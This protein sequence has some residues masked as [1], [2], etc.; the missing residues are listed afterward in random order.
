MAL[1]K[2]SLKTAIMAAF[3]AQQNKT[4]NPEGALNDLADKLATAIDTYIKSGTVN[5]TVATTGSATAQAGTG[6]GNIV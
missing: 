2:T 6:T 1:V 5:V 3:K 4:D